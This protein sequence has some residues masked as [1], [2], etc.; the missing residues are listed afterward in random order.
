MNRTMGWGFLGVLFATSLGLNL[1]AQTFFMRVGEDIHHSEH[2]NLAF[3]TKVRKDSLPDGENEVPKTYFDLQI[4]DSALLEAMDVF[5]QT[6][7]EDPEQIYRGLEALGKIE[8]GPIVGNQIQA[9]A[10]TKTEKA[11][12]VGLLF[13]SSLLILSSFETYDLTPGYRLSSLYGLFF[14]VFPFEQHYLYKTCGDKE[15]LVATTRAPVSEE[16]EAAAKQN[17]KVYEKLV[18][19]FKLHALCN[20]PKTPA[21]TDLKSRS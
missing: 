10:P 21:P 6:N 13:L 3:T 1:Q 16:N 5:T 18:D 4:S 12:E 20:T 19:I 17:E 11:M 14:F 8:G 7:F 9:R 15:Y 2:L